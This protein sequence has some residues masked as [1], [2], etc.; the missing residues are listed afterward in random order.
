M[1]TLYI[2]FLSITFAFTLGLGALS[3]IAHNYI[4]DLSA[5]E[6]YSPGKPSILLDDEGVEWGRF[7]LDRR[8]PIPLK[9]VPL[10]VQQAFL[11]AEDRQFFSHTGISWRSII[12]SL[13]INLIHWRKVQGASTI[14]QQLVRLLFFDNKKT[15]RRKIKEQLCAL[16]I[17]RQCTKEQILQTYLNT[18]CFGCGIYGIQAAAQ[19]F[20]GIPAAELSL[21]QGATLAAIIKCP[22]RY[23]PLVNPALTHTRRNIVLASMRD[24]GFMNAQ[25]CQQA[26]HEPLGLIT[27]SPNETLAPHLK[28]AIA[29]FVEEHVGKLALYKNGLTI[30]TTINKNTQKQAEAIFYRYMSTLKTQLGTTVD[31]ALVSMNV[32]SG[33]ITALIGGYD[34]KKSQFNRAIQ[35]RRQLGSVFKPIVYAAALL[36][37]RTF[38][39]TDIDEP[40]EFIHGT[41]HWTPQNTTKTFDGVMTLARAL[42]YSN[43]IIAAKTLM[44]VGVENVVAL[45]RICKL[46]GPC[47]PYPSLALGCIEASPLEAV[48]T[49]NI[50]A[51]DGLYVAPH[52]IT[53]IKDQNGEKIYHYEQTCERVLDSRIVGQVKKTLTLGFKRYIERVKVTNFAP[54]VMCKTGTTNDSRTCWFAGAT[55]K[56]TTIVYIGRDDNTPLGHDIYP[57]WTAFPIWLDFN[58]VIN[59][60]PQQFTYDPRLKEITID[61]KTGLPAK[62]DN[63]EAVTLYV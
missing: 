27:L 31:G 36:A 44:R 24:A 49:F 61:W 63:P 43:N 20:W 16:F 6:N 41:S 23:C 30:K 53:W 50:F 2:S 62:A 15:F 33:D 59:N 38:V 19:R 9:D 29:Q 3:Y 21:A 7:E 42:S 52:F 18:I 60:T 5:L 46:A 26:Q 1:R 51:H 10:H 37:G 45:A 22:A 14:T 8:E 17:E 48:G 47:S 40:I 54:E 39:D 28:E 13:C 34:F 32:E 56:L 11:A 55:P 57:L 4:V 35:A 12:R 25:Q 58:K